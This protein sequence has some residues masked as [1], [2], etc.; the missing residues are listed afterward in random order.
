[1]GEKDVRNRVWLRREC[2]ENMSLLRRR[3]YRGPW[4]RA[5]GCEDCE[6]HGMQ[7][8]IG[9]HCSWRPCNR[10]IY[11]KKN[12]KKKVLLAFISRGTCVGEGTIKAI[13][14][15]KEKFHQQAQEEAAN[16]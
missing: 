3:N 10:C 12:T 4:R 14:K 16:H 13:D 15:Q 6:A 8:N 2:Q 9:Q 7:Q 1:M 5:E 11:K